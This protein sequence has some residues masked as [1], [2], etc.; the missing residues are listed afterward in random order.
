MA[1]CCTP[2]VFCL[3]AVLLAGCRVCSAE[4]ACS[5]AN[6]LLG[7]KKLTERDKQLLLD[8]HNNYRDLI[9]SGSLAEQPAAQNMLQLNWDD[10]AA[11]LAHR[12]ASGCQFA[13]N[14]PENKDG[15]PMGQ[16]LYIKMSTRAQNVNKTF[17][18]WVK[19]MV[20]GWFDEVQLYA[21]GDSFSAQTGHYTQMVWAKT[22]RLGCGYSYYLQDFWY[23]GYLVCNYSPAGNYV[24]QK[25]YRK[26]KINCEVHD[27]EPSTRYKN[28]C[29]NK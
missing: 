26:G 3:F 9:A 29:I 14:T 5:N 11:Q 7:M 25:P 27:L 24:G 15:S 28:L 22:A 4:L 20:K 17:S 6:T 19:S 12:W 10:H 13:H 8:L 16:N 2:L 1:R 21:Y 18:A 23:V